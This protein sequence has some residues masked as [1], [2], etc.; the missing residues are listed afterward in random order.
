MKKVLLMGFAFL[1]TMIFGLSAHAQLPAPENLSCGLADTDGDMSNDSVCCS[2]DPVID[3]VK[4]SL[5]IDIPVDTSDPADGIADMVV[6]L[7]F[8]TSDRTD[9]GSMSDPNLCVFLSDI[10][11]DINGDTVPDQLSGDADIKV[12]ALDPG[13]GKGSQNNPFSI[14][15]TVTLP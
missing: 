14:P 15:V 13:K 12:K 10:T 7:S 4:Y 9:G 11:Y 5:D 3:A 8:G 6:E 2:W 1:I